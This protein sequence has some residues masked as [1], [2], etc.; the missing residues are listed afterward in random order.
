MQLPEKIS[1][2]LDQIKAK[3]SRSVTV[4]LIN[5]GYYLYEYGYA[6]DLKKGK[7]RPFTFYIGKIEEDGRFVEA[8][9]RFLKTKAKTINEYIKELQ[10]TAEKEEVKILPEGDALSLLKEISMNARASN[11]EIAKATGLKQSKVAHM[12]HKLSSVYGIRYTIEMRPE[13]FGFSRY[14]IIIKFGSRIPDPEALKKILENE[15]KVQYAALTSG[16]YGAIFYVLEESNAALEDFIYQLR[17]K[18]IFERAPGLWYVSYLIEPYGWYVPFRDEFFEMLK[19]RVWTR[20][21]DSP[22]RTKT[23]LLKTEYAI[24]RE[25]N[26]NSR[27]RFTD[28]DL[29]YGFGS[30]SSE[31]AYYK[32]IQKGTIKR[33]TIAMQEPGAKFIAL[34]YLKQR[35]I[36]LFNKTKANYL[37]SIIEE[38]YYP[39]NKFVYV[40]DSS[41]PN[42]ITLL[43]PIYKDGDLENIV[44]DLQKNVKGIEI[45][46]AII[47]S[48]LIGSLGIRKF[49]MKES[50]QFALLNKLK[51]EKEPVLVPK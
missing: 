7:V 34:L 24:L 2:T 47:T 46:K 45:K 33:A 26:R 9:H 4:K 44:A 42:G 11:A 51:L 20:T 21:R 13:T 22:R 43:A 1:K 3:R 29:E 30:G 32:L 14:M 28:I 17:S 38:T 25:M 36:N 12:L 6:K 37:R 10:E 50:S 5:G 31:Y 15:P 48:N 35:N 39:S 41:S 23:Q 40:A 19:N 16:D 27:S 49:S 18:S 8:R